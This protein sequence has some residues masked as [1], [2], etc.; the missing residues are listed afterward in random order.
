MT[1]TTTP[2]TI[3]VNGG[4]VLIFSPKATKIRYR[5]RWTGPGDPPPNAPELDEQHEAGGSMN[6]AA[7]WCVDYD[8]RVS[9]SAS[10]HFSGAVHRARNGEAPADDK[11][12]DE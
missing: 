10:A 12:D 8:L 9:M 6:D 2:H 7:Q 5:L 1:A 3:A 11:D 4:W